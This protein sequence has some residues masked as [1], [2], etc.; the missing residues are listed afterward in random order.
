MEGKAEQHLILERKIFDLT[1]AWVLATILLAIL[2]FVGGLVFTST[3]SISGISLL[4]GVI[5]LPVIFL[6][7][8][9]VTSTKKLFALARLNT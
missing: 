2:G 1:A 8:Y 7:V 6:F 5:S 9:L 3:D 4:G